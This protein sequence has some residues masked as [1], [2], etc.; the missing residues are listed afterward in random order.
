MT[1]TNKSKLYHY[2]TCGL[3]NVYLV[4]GYDIV[5][6][7]YGRGVAI[8]DVDGLHRIIGSHVVG[9][10]RPLSGKEFR[11]LRIEMDM[12]QKALG[13]ILGKS[14]QAVALWE[15]GDKVP[16]AEDLLI[17]QLYIETVLDD[18][19]LLTDLVELINELDRVFQDIEEFCFKDSEDG[20]VD[21]EA[22]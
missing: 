21:A 15:K 7:V 12:S 19:P 20:W 17:R 3:D 5:E 13:A 16:R 8:H 22:A 11:F 18:N 6:T 2:D 9:L 10:K 14:D 4:N 1:C